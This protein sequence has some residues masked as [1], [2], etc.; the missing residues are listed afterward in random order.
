MEAAMYTA[1]S[2]VMV[3][4]FSKEGDGNNDDTMDT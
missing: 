1:V 4:M 2:K 3:Q